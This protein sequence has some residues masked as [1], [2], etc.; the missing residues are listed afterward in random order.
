MK[1]KYEDPFRVIL[2]QRTY[3]LIRVDGRA[4]HT[5]T[6]SF[7]RPFDQYL[8]DGMVVAGLETMQE[9][10]G[11]KFAFGQSDEFSFVATDFDTHESQMWFG[12][13]KSKIESITASVFTAEFNRFIR[14]LRPQ[15][16]NAYFDARAFIIPME[17]EVINYFVWRQQDTIR[18][19]VSM[20]ARHY[21]SAKKL[22][23]V[24]TAEAKKLLA[25]EGVY[26]NKQPSAFRRG[27]ALYKPEKAIDNPPPGRSNGWL[28]DGDLP[29]FAH[30]PSFVAQH[31][32]SE[33]D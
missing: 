31:L 5:Y 9:I 26:W 21:F 30:N 28:V 2:P 12:G 15:L 33:G 13:N 18:N 27:T 10:G 32:P 3:L 24:S 23:G 6:K 22:H 4:F 11:A 8:H 16:K 19:S 25:K 17:H 14:H 29:L 20:L 1:S 7:N